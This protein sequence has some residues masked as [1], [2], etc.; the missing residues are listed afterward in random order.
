MSKAF[1]CDRCKCCFDPMLIEEPNHF[2]TIPEYFIQNGSDYDN[3]KVGICEENV[4]LCQKCSKDFADFMQLR[5]VPKDMYDSL[6]EDF[7]FLRLDYDGLADD[8]VQILD[9][10]D[11]NLSDMKQ[12]L[13]EELRHANSKEVHNFV[14]DAMHNLLFGTGGGDS[15][16][17]DVCPDKI[18][19]RPKR[20]KKDSK[21]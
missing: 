13:M 19:E 3:R 16:K 12:V 5:T 6:K 14:V 20:T 10:L 15:G 1:K 11:K 2:T 21:H 4:H 18:A 7:E 9:L 8:K 17:S